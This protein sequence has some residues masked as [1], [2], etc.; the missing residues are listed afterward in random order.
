MLE[1]PSVTHLMMVTHDAG[2]R[3]GTST[4]S[5]LSSRSAVTFLERGQS[6][7]SVSVTDDVAASD[8]DCSLGTFSTRPL[9][10]VESDSD[11]T[12]EV[13]LTKRIMRARMVLILMKTR[14]NFEPK[15]KQKTL[16]Q[17]LEGPCLNI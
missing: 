16:L 14:N 7:P 2:L 4:V 6:Q 11:D 9:M 15:W 12:V 5:S 3:T 13:I 1:T 17:E 8:D 10:H